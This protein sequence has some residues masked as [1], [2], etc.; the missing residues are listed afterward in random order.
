M[1]LKKIIAGITALAMFTV[2]SYSGSNNFSEL[3]G[4][5]SASA[6]DNYSGY[7]GEN[8]TYSFDETTG[9]LTISG[10]GDMYDYSSIAGLISS[11]NPEVERE[12]PWSCQSSIEKIVINDGVTSI[13]GLAF[14]YC[15][16]LV[17]ISIPESV[18][19][20]NPVAFSDCT[21]LKDVSIPKG[22]TY[23]DNF[24]F[25]SCTSLEN[26]N[27][28]KDNNYYSSENG[29]LFD[30]DKTKL[31]TYPIG[32]NETEY[33][34]PNGVT[35]IGNSAF[36]G[37]TS[38][39]AITI[40]NGVYSIGIASFSGCVSLTDIN[41]PDS[42][43]YVGEYT[44]AN[45]TSLKKIPDGLKIISS[46]MFFC[47]TSLVNVIIPS[48]V[49]SIGSYAFSNCTS[50]TDVN[51]A[52]SVKSIDN[53]AFVHCELL[54]NV[55]IPDGV[56]TIG[57]SAFSYCTSLKEVTIPNSVT[58]I[59]SVA[60]GYYYTN[61][62]SGSLTK[63]DDFTIKGYKNSTAET[64]ANENEFNFVALD[65]PAEQLIG[66]I[67]GDGTVASTDALIILQYVTATTELTDEQK[68][69]ADLDGDGEITSA[70]AL[71]VL[72]IVVGLK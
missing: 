18:K 47:C 44:F 25:A 23:V 24:A 54:T 64:Y 33:I 36:E 20:I 38:L 21:S 66:D 50:L 3:T 55:N 68:K 71:E 31:V 8:C 7:C 32:K 46:N 9:T 11:I 49:T 4:I 61:N 6:E 51:I 13:G 69:L 17:E 60:F 59:G 41:I 53:F 22:V 63:I 15:E 37:C 62:S 56:E 39:T 14:A 43:T 5:I 40:P 10:T 2:V 35:T 42:V 65:N 70:D 12:V 29:V 57:N 26:I 16:S 28:D 30:K 45:C 72:Q 58:S 67:D 19:S 52:D 1:K 48:G 34:I 27:V